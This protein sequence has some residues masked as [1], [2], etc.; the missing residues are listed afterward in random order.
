MR[1][2]NFVLRVVVHHGK[3]DVAFRVDPHSKR[4]PISHKDPLTDVEFPL[5]D[6]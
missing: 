5:V 4:I 2:P 1:K 3:S 6:D